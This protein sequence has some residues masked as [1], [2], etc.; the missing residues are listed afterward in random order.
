MTIPT[1]KTPTD[2]V[3]VIGS[4]GREHA[5]AFALAK[6]SLVAKVYVAP[7]NGGTALSNQFS[8]SQHKDSITSPSALNPSAETNNP[9]NGLLTD[10]IA[11]YHAKIENVNISATD[12][13]GLV[14]FALDKNISLVVP[15]PEQP[16]V[17]GIT[18]IF[19]KK[20]GIPVFGPSQK[21]AQLEGSKAFSKSFMKRH[22][23]PTAQFETFTD[24]ESAVKYFDDYVAEH[25]N[26]ELP[27]IKASGLAAG[28]GVVLP[29][30]VKEAKETL[31]SILQDNIFGDAGSEVVIEERLSGEEVSILSITDGHSI[32]S[33][34]AAQ[35]HKRIFDGDLGPNT[36]GMGAYAPAPVYT[37]DLAISVKKNILQPTIDGMRRDGIPFV[38][39]LYTGLILTSLGPYVLEYNCRFGD[40]ETQAVLPLI[41]DS[42]DLFQVL[43]AASESRLDSV[44][45]DFKKEYSVSVVLASKGYPGSYEK[46]IEITLPPYI[47]P[48]INIFHA[49][50]KLIDGLK[51][52]T[53][54]GRVIA[55]NA[56]AETL[57]EAIAR[58]KKYVGR[59][60]FNGMQFRQDI[61][62]KALKHIALQETKN[63]D[64]DSK[65]Q[66]GESL[67][68]NHL[69]YA[70]AG[71]N[72]DAGNLL[73]QKI[74]PF[75]KSTKRIGADADLG[76]FGGNF[77]LAAILEK[78]KNPILV[79]GAD[80]VGSKIKIA[81]DT[82]IN[83][84][85]GI[86]L[87]AMNA[88]DVVVQGAEPLFF[89][90]YYSC[91]KLDV[92]VAAD[93]V[94]GIAEGCKMADCALIGG[95]TSEMPG[96][97]P[98]DEYDLAGFVVGIVDKDKMLPKFDEIRPGDLV[99]GLPSSG[100]HSNGFSLVRKVLQIAELDFSSP[101][102]FPSATKECSTIGEVLLT[103]TRIYVKQILPLTEKGLVRGMAHITGGGFI[104]NIPRCIP[105]DLAVTMDARCWELPPVF[106]WLKKVANIEDAELSRAFNCGIGMVLIIS[107]S[108]LEPVTKILREQ[109]E[110]VYQIGK[111]VSRED[112][113]DSSTQVEV[114]GTEE[115][116]R[117]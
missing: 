28:K 91:G 102:P 50:T 46:G 57:T 79:S 83:D 14:K 23:I 68:N 29:E 94:K 2:S 76:G 8:T 67:N 89:L 82:R 96:M 110:Q 30:T 98:D 71:V 54:G 21:G 95:E 103:P 56:V 109:G 99:L 25:P 64:S 24:L 49:G 26:N 16:L 111:V 60:S 4:G 37:K 86:D 38:G 107:K 13:D 17:D 34:P 51:L 43:L 114:L 22:H 18:D 19:R 72:I 78:Y 15:G 73:V 33:F 101:C 44:S 6:S 92:D 88:N 115:A 84:T 116:W 55:V 106:R 48:D 61:G 1:I 3:L 35:D 105:K 58:A 90:D 113:V 93:V 75:V 36:G 20:S 11:S 77:N 80:G 41:A 27:V 45:M 104:E 42:S 59:I 47:S 52:V 65:P 100:V 108:N 81:Q 69:T 31:K 40:P 9:I 32:L 12:Y 74:K 7:G 112:L 62:A 39:V 85:V 117:V 97:Y 10:R 66:N 5:L 87:V 70:A 53:S 63:E